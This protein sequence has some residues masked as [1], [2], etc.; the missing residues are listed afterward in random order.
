VRGKTPKGAGKTRGRWKDEKGNIYE[1]DSQHETL[2][3]YNKRG[4]HL[5]E[6]NKDTDEQLKSA[7]ST[8]R[9]DP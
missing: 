5:G 9:I 2:E 4:K 7:N 6:F 3:K 1:W 8:R